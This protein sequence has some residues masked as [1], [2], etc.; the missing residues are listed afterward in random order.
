M[1]YKVFISETSDYIPKKVNTNY[2][3]MYP[4]YQRE[5]VCNPLQLH[6]ERIIPM[7]VP[8]HQYNEWQIG[9]PVDHLLTLEVERLD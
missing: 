5:E 6:I 9:I 3:L 7:Q 1:I 2:F 8:K 4:Y